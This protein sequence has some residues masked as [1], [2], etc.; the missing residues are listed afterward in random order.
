M[1]RERNYGTSPLWVLPLL[2]L[3][4]IWIQLGEFVTKFLTFKPGTT[5]C[6]LQC[7]APLITTPHPRQTAWNT[8]LILI[9][10]SICSLPP[11][12]WHIYKDLLLIWMTP[13][14]ESVPIFNTSDWICLCNFNSSIYSGDQPLI[15][16][17]Y[18]WEPVLLSIFSCTSH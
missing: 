16:T 14:T 13:F 15:N 3:Q 12:K 17:V 1:Q 5:Q 8:F 6:L 9:Q 2:E 7:S 10:E 18:H 11:D 4:L